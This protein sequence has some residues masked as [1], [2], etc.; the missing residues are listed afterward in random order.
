MKVTQRGVVYAL[1]PSPLDVNRL[2]A[3]TDDGLIH[4]TTDGGATWTN[5]TPPSLVPW[6]KV[7]ILEASHFDANEA[8]AAIDP[9]GYPGL[10]VTQLRDVGLWRTVEDAGG[11]LA[12]AIAQ[13]LHRR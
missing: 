12:P 3:G 1:A 10:A 6:A 5:V 7:S 4:V 8:Y 9:C 11:E 13:A 2:W